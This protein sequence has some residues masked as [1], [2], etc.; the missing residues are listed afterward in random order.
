MAHIRLRKFNTRTTYPEQ[1]LS[2]DLSQ[3]VLARGDT[4][5]VLTSREAQEIAD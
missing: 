2:N 4:W 1:N 3:A 5:R